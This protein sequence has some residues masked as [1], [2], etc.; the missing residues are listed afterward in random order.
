MFRKIKRI[1]KNKYLSLLLTVQTSGGG[2]LRDV[3]TDT[4][5]SSLRRIY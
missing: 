5:V 2:V 3:E 1:M 4:V